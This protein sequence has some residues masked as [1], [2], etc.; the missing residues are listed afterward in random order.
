MTVN[1]AV[2]GVALGAEAMQLFSLLHAQTS[3]VLGLLKPQCI[4]ISL[5]YIL[6]CVLIIDFIVLF[7][8]LGKPKNKN[9]KQSLIERIVMPFETEVKF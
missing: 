6:I 5:F 8:I 4:T 9:K 3:T 1:L 7:S 2:F